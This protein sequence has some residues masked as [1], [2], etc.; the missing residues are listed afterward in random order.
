M[1]GKALLWRIEKLQCAIFLGH[2]FCFDYNFGLY[3]EE[4]D[5]NKS[6]TNSNIDKN[7]QGS[8]KVLDPSNPLG[9][10]TMRR[11]GLV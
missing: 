5:T 8:L 6:L 11:W 9:S 4:S 10:V 3:Q 1:K 7:N 2:S